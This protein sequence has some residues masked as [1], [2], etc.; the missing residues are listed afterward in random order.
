MARQL[1][2]EIMT[3]AFRYSC[4]VML[5]TTIERELRRLVQNLEKQ[6]ERKS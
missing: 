3:P 5:Y 1:H 6:R 2:D 4:I